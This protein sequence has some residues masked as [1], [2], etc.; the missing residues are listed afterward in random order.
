MRVA[1]AGSADM[2]IGGAPAGVLAALQDDGV[3][4]VAPF[5]NEN[6]FLVITRADSPINTVHDLR[7]RKLGFSRPGSASQG[8]LNLMLERAG[9][10]DVQWVATGP[11]GDTWT[12]VRGG[13]VD[14]GWSQD[15]MAAGLVLKGEAKVVVRAA[16][17]VPDYFSDFVLVRQDFARQHPQAVRGF[18]A[19]LDRTSR[20]IAANWQELIPTFAAYFGDAEDIMRATVQSTDVER[21]WSVK[22]FPEAFK[23]IEQTMR[24]SGQIKEPVPW[25]RIFDQQYLPE[26]ERAR[27]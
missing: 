5:N 10:R 11:M 22:V 21:A 20:Y 2:A 9:V 14:A 18:L 7:G 19:T 6:P 16:E 23:N 15:P 4:L 27:L 25:D 1:T 13:V 8:I 17:Y 26:S 12:A 3:K 24:D